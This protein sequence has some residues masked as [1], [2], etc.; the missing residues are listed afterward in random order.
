MTNDFRSIR[1]KLKVHGVYSSP[2]H[3]RATK[4]NYCSLRRLAQRN[5]LLWEEGE[6]LNFLNSLV[7]KE[8]QVSEMK[9]GS[10]L[11][12]RREAEGGNL[13]SMHL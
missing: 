9:I 7:Q 2:Q 1:F 3:E 11:S 4:G 13:Y 10:H 5:L 8:M 12:G 6:C